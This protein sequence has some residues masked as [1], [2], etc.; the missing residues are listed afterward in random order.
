[1]K[2]HTRRTRPAFTLVELITV[3]AIIAL[4]AGLVVAGTGFAKQRQAS[5]KAKV[6]IALLSKAIEEFKADMGFYPGDLDNTPVDGNVSKELYQALFKDGYDYTNT[7]S[8]SSTWDKATR[9]Y[10]PELDPRNN[11]LG[12]VTRTTSDT[13]GDNLD[14][15]DPWGSGYRYRKGSDAQN[16]DFD[17]WSMGKDGKTNATN[18]DTTLDENR[19][20]I[21]NF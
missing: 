15:L 7:S 9:I 8:P 2:V 19:D 14:I 18:P 1:M 17:V 20:D 13:P 3:I 12:W 16:P 21:R 6:Q 11:K 10:L 5:E 4:L